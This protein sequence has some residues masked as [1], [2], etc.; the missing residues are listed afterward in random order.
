MKFN[1]DERIEIKNVDAAI[2][3]CA[4]VRKHIHVVGVDTEDDTYLARVFLIE[5]MDLFFRTSPSF[6]DRKDV[7]VI[8]DYKQKITTPFVE[9]WCT[10]EELLYVGGYEDEI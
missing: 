1:L 3:Q 4:D 7:V 6:L 8:E 2:L 5:D 10:E 9:Y